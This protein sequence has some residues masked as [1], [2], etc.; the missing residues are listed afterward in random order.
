MVGQ[1]VWFVRRGF[2]NILRMDFG[3]PH[4]AIDGPY[5]ASPASSQKAVNALD[6]R[7]VQPTGRWHLFVDDGDWSVTTKR[8]QCRRLDTDLKNVD[9]TL[10]QLDGQKILK[11]DY[12][13]ETGEWIFE[14]DLG[15]LLH[16]GLSK[17]TD[18][19]A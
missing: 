5:R 7:T 14:F 11:I 8:H 12:K 16:I 9:E 3:Q 10:R 17:N 6:R 2:E 4:L 1:Y 18:D 13:S 15:G 19:M